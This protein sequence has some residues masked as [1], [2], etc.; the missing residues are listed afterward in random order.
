YVTPH[1]W[2]EF[3]HE[4]AL[5]PVVEPDQRKWDYRHQVL[6]Q[7]HLKPWQLFAAVKWLELWFHLRPSRLWAI[8]TSRDPLRRHQLLWSSVHTGLVWVGEVF[9][10]VRDLFGR[11]ADQRNVK[12]QV[13]P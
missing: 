12:A 7:R 2:T 4:A 5:R 3:G 9:Q 13:L 8:L 11:S 1:S 6:G 10:H